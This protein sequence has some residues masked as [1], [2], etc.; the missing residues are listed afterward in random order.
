MRKRNAKQNNINLFLLCLTK[1]LSGFA[2]YIY[3]IGIVIYLFQETESVVAIGGFFVS[4]FLPAFIVLIMGGIID[5]YNKK[6]LLFFSN[7]TKV[8]LMLFLLFNRDIWSVYFVTFFMNLILEFEN[9]ASSALMVCAFSKDKLF[10]TASIV[11]FIDSFSLIVA[12]LCASAIALYFKVNINLGINSILFGSSAVLYSFFKS[13]EK[14]REEKTQQEKRKMGYKSI[15]CNRSILRA[16]FFWNIFMFCIGITSPLEIGM[17]EGTLKMSSSWYGIGNAVE[18]IGMLIASIFIL[19]RIT[20]LKPSSIIGI[21]LF[22]AAFSYIIIGIS[23][24]IWIYFI[25]ACLVGVTATFAPLGFKTEIQMECKAEFIGRA[26]TM[27]RFSVLLSRMVGALVVGHILKICNIR[28]V[29]YGTAA[30]LLGAALV[31]NRKQ[32]NSNPRT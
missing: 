22:S 12:P 30:I 5:K 29:Y 3:D 11:N 19:G 7:I 26:F 6:Y 25:G 23:N 27:S 18:G 17:I 1:F 15:T 20:K 10:R 2:G 14:Y 31:Y 9:S 13:E 28:L 24:N 16:V 21:G 32:K 4:Q 8:V